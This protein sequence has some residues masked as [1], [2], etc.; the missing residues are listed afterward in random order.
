MKISF[1]KWK[2]TISNYI[3]SERISEPNSLNEIDLN[4]NIFKEEDGTILLTKFDQTKGLLFISVSQACLLAG[5]QEMIFF[6]GTFKVTPSLFYQ[7]CPFQIYINQYKTTIL[8]ALILLT[9]KSRNHYEYA[10]NSS[11]DIVTN[12]TI[13]N[14][15]YEPKQFMIDKEDE[16]FLSIKTVWPNTQI[17]LCYFHFGQKF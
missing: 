17:K 13:R 6:D 16:I 1:N 7:L 10:F 2:Q 4:N 9:G 11:K 12:Y 8:G 5:Y 14:I 15:P 3:E